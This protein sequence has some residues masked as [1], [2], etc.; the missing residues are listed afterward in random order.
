[1]IIASSEVERPNGE[2]SGT[3]CMNACRTEDS[4]G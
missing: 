2:N 4:M 1:M 3:D